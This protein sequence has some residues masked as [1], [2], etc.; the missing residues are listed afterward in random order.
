MRIA[1]WNC[2]G[3]FRTKHG[4]IAE[5]GPDIAVISECEEPPRLKGAYPT[6]QFADALWVGER[7]S[8]GLAI[9]VREGLQLK[10]HDS[11]SPEFTHI[12]PAVIAGDFA[13]TLIA[14]WI[15]PSQYLK[16]DG[17]L[18]Y[19]F[20]HYEAILPGC[21]IIAGDWNTNAVWDSKNGEGFT[22][23]QKIVQG[24]GFRSAYHETYQER[25]G[26]ESRPT[27]FH[28]KGPTSPYHVDYCFVNDRAQYRIESVTVGNH[29]EWLGRSDH[30]PLF[31]DIHTNGRDE[32]PA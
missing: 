6:A 31:V 28:R 27:L 18:F 22:A 15:K 25:F 16:Y 32:K 24:H 8:R 3:S 1:V 29:R 17:Q 14:T 11:Y 12:V 26:G 13:L 9:L 5:H 10:R 4:Y 30:M 19:G 2:A 7:P 23:I 20:R 21:A